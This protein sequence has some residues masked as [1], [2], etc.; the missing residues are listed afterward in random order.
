MWE[1]EAD[2]NKIVKFIN[3]QVQFL[4]NSFKK[5][6]KYYEINCFIPGFS[7]TNSIYTQNRG[8]IR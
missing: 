7:F 4:N 1:T 6:L 5:P 8:K 2:A 3:N